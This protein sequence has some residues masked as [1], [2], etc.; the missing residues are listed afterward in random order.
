MSRSY[1]CVLTY[2]V[3]LNGEP[4][5]PFLQKLTAAIGR[6]IERTA[7]KRLSQNGGDLSVLKRVSKAAKGGGDE[8][9]KNAK[10]PKFNTRKQFR[11]TS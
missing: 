11:L 10:V 8:S 4:R 7:G 3:D 9:S 5:N 1:H 2:G 6:N